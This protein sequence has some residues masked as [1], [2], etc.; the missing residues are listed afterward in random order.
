V[1][2]AAPYIKK[3]VLGIAVGT[4]SFV[5]LMYISEHSPKRLR[6]GMTALN[7]FMIVLL[8]QPGCI[9]RV[10]RPE[11]ESGRGQQP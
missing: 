10:R 4:A 3:F 1:G 8:V 2:G 11:P 7:Q 5:A 6:G 9:W